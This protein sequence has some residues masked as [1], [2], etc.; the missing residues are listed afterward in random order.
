VPFVPPASP[1]RYT[2]SVEQPET[3]EAETAVE[4]IST[5]R[6]IS[7]TTWRDGGHA[8]RSV[9]AKSHGLLQ[10]EMEVLAHGYPVLAQ[11][12]F[13]QA[14]RHPVIMRFST[15]P[16]DLL[17]D[18]VST[19]R[20]LAIKVFDV[21]G[22]R[23]PGSEGQTTQD[24]VLIN[25]PAFGA[26]NTKVFLG[27][28]KLLAGT[29]D[30]LAGL[31]KALSA[32]LQPI[33]EALEKSGH[34]SATLT[35]LGGHPQTHVLGETYF[36]QAAL[37]FG[38]YIAKIAVAPVSPELVALH[39]KHID[40]HNRPNG[41]RE[42]VVDFFANHGGEWEVRVQLCAD[43][44]KMP[45]ENAAKVWPEETSPYV[46]VARIRAEPQTG[47]CE[48]RSIAVDDGLAFSPW[49]GLAAHQPLGSIMRVR[50]RAYEM[51]AQ[52]RAEHNNRATDEPRSFTPLPD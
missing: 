39:H 36:S 9:H 32:V 16:G 48:A 26:P 2:P 19:P 22:E 25:G 15:I 28:L 51:S 44:E 37:R 18:S 10:G 40:L 45:V 3:D 42:A 7:E 23:L 34:P 50:R 4:L 27:N 43:L 20:G 6:S 31:K 29:T 33:E 35:T 13:A 14:G 11:G 30:K 47:W 46:P 38:D 1:V 49:H 5:M 17:D 21:A 52:F 12:L 41:L 24:F 8:I